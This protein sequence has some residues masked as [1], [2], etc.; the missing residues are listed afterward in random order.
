MLIP[1]EGVLPKV[2]ETA[3]LAETAVIIGDVEIGEH[4]SVWYNCV[5]RG[6]HM[7]IRVGKRTN[8]Q[9]GSILH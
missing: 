1:F 2:H 9:D 8:I 4:S 7:P 5:L 3:W 6:D